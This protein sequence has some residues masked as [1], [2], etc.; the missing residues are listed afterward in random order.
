VTIN[1]LISNFYSEETK[2]S[3]IAFSFANLDHNEP[4]PFTKFNSYLIDYAEEHGANRMIFRYPASGEFVF[5][6][7]FFRTIDN[8]VTGKSITQQFNA[9]TFSPGQKV[10]IGNAFAQFEG[11]FHGERDGRGSISFNEAKISSDINYICLKF[12]SRGR[13]E[14]HRS[15]YLIKDIPFIEPVSEKQKLSTHQEFEEQRSSTLQKNIFIE[16]FTKVWVGNQPNIG[17]CS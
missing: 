7:V 16:V 17:F 11:F 3:K 10:K 5:S 12:S 8:L 15:Y 1:E 6:L 14:N 13:G 9:N 2:E 4:C